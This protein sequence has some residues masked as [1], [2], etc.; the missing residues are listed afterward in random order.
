MNSTASITTSLRLL[1]LVALSFG[2]LSDLPERTSLNG[3]PVRVPGNLDTHFLFDLP[4]PL[5]KL[6]FLGIP[7]SRGIFKALVAW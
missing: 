1:L 2:L 6:L 5:L 4:D 7:I 3:G